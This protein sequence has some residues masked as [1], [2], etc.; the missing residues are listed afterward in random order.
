M[1]NLT[2]TLVGLM[3]ART[4]LEKTTARGAGMMMIAANLPDIDAVTWFNRLAYLD[5]HRSYTHAFAVSP[6]M[7]VI[8]LLLVRARFRWPAYLA[9]LAG[10][11]SHILLDWT[12]A[13]GIQFLL[14]FSAQRSQLDITNIVDLWIWAILL[15]ALL[16][17]ALSRVVSSEIGD[18][19][20][21][22]VRRA[23]AW[24]ALIA[25]V[26][27]EGARFVAHERAVGMISARLYQGAPP[28]EVIAVP[29]GAVSPF[30]WRGIVRG[31]GF[32]TIVPVNVLKA[33]DPAQ[34]RTF[35]EAKPGAAIEEARRL[36]E[37][38]TMIRF[39]KAQF[40]K[41]LPGASGTEVQLIDLRFGTPDNAGFAAVS[42]IVKR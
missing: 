40:W 2:H 14:P 31:D 37:F 12:N 8:P 1:E 15:I 3:M 25:L 22:P 26:S 38:Q 29:V 10:V 36:P 6:V 9:S 19:K 4:G 32:A 27:Y 41:V 11:L 28:R 24:V 42:T 20:S 7:A 30:E 35:Y 21:L 17:T 33:F 39:S 23:W 18:A 5:W 16:A 13:Y 34:G